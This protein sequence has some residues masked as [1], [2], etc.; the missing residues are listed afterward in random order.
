MRLSYTKLLGQVTIDQINVDKTDLRSKSV[1]PNTANT[2]NFMV[3][4][5]P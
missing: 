1:K 3:S 4:I 2:P 5:L